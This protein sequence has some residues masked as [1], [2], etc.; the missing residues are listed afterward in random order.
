MNDWGNML[1]IA[2]INARVLYKNSTQKQIYRRKFILLLMKKLTNTSR[3]EKSSADSDTPQSRPI[4]FTTRKRRH[5]HGANCNNMTVTLCMKCNRPS[6][7]SCSKNNAR[8]MY[9][10]YKKCFSYR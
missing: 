7:G 10:T 4:S 5:C 2:A 9:V 3:M 6:C 1:D 8:V